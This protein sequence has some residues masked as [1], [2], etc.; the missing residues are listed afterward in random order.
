MVEPRYEI[1]DRL[2][3]TEIYI[4][5]LAIIS[6]GS[7]RYF[8]QAGDNTFVFEAPDVEHLEVLAQ[9]IKKPPDEI[10]RRSDRNFKH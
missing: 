2:P 8:L 1:G 3:G 7:T 9:Y 10:A 5:G 4:R 6:D